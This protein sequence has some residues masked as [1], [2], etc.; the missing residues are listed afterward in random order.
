MTSCPWRV[1]AA[2]HSQRLRSDKLKLRRVPGSSVDMRETITLSSRASKFPALDRSQTP[3]TTD[4]PE[5]SEKNTTKMPEASNAPY[6]VQSSSR[7]CKQMLVA[8]TLSRALSV[9]S[10][11]K[12]RSKKADK[13]FY[14]C[15]KVEKISQFGCLHYSQNSVIVHK[16][17]NRN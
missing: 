12:K 15:E 14:S 9:I 17:K 7:T 13:R 10:V 6:S 8:D 2:E 4:Q 3:D 1:F 11:C 5:R 16:E